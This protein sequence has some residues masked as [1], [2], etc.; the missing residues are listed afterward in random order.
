MVTRYSSKTGEWIE[1]KYHEWNEKRF[2]LE[3]ARSS[4]DFGDGTP[5]PASTF[6]VTLGVTYYDNDL[7]E[8]YMRVYLHDGDRNEK[9]Y[10]LGDSD[11]HF[12]I[13]APRLVDVSS[14]FEE[15]FTEG[16]PGRMYS[17]ID[18]FVRGAAFLAVKSETLKAGKAGEFRE[19]LRDATR[20]GIEELIVG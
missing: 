4:G 17:A 13:T 11:I 10:R 6:R 9:Q 3:G 16:T 7:L 19:K 20:S 12:N 8:L 5:E 1:S 15:V 14:D 2:A 18:E